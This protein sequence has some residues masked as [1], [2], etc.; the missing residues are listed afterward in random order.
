MNFYIYIESLSLTNLDFIY[1]TPSLLSTIPKFCPNLKE[2]VFC[3]PEEENL[4]RGRFIEEVVPPIDVVDHFKM[5]PKVTK[6]NCIIKL[7]ISKKYFYIVL[8]SLKQSR[9]MEYRQNMSRLF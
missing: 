2:V 4:G 6:K 7:N 1:F 8:N 5:W 9:S 3:E